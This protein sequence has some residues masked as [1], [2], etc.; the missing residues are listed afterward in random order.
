[1][2]KQFVHKTKTRIIGIGGGGSSIVCEIADKISKADFL[3][4]NTDSRA[5]KTASPKIKKVQ[6][7]IKLTN[8][9]GTG[10]NPE[11]AELAAQEEKDKLKKIFE[12]QDLVIIISSLGAGT[13]SGA[14][15]VLAKIAKSTGAITYG[16]F[17]L[18]FEFEGKKKMEIAQEALEKIKTNFNAYTIFP[19]ERIFKIIDKNTPLKESF[20]L[21]NKKLAENLKGLIETIYLPGLINIDFADLKTILQGQ[22]KLT[23]LNYLEIE[24]NNIEEGIKK[25]ITSPFFSYDISGAKGILYNITGSNDLQLSEVSGISKLIK[26]L[27]NN[28][29]KIIF[30][31]S[32]DNKAKNKIGITLLATGCGEK[33]KEQEKKPIKKIKIKKPP[34]TRKNALEIK[35]TTDQEEQKLIEQED[36]WETP[37][38]LRK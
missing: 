38:I 9:L 35:K 5:L 16:I 7:G 19:N 22:G 8:G 23:F 36:A 29:A 4:I 37:A 2:K 10:M 20:S 14:T 24:K 34:K 6:F 17:T 30:G 27:A 1:M 21:I 13:G 31:I 15:P 33:E 26:D 18:P 3:I 32:N 11:L 12:D 28:K 25:V